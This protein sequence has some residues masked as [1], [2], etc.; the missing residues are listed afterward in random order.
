MVRIV[1]VRRRGPF[2]LR[3]WLQELKCESTR[4][5]NKH[6]LTDEFINEYMLIIFFLIKKKTLTS[7]GRNKF[8]SYLVG[9]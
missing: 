8:S 2:N 7:N 4:H 6:I 5:I 3:E 1:A 9:G